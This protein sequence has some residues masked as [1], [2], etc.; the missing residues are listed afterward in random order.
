MDRSLLS[1]EAEYRCFRFRKHHSSQFSA[2]RK[3]TGKKQASPAELSATV[4]TLS[5]PNYR[6][7]WA[8]R[9]I[10][11]AYYGDGIEPSSYHMY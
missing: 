2:A 9:I 6:Y 8:A 5:W 7:Y 11:Y 1:G 4:T 3:D 10:W